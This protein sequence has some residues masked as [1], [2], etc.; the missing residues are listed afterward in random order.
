[1]EVLV[2]KRYSSHV[3]GKLSHTLMYAKGVS[4]SSDQGLNYFT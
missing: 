1:M 2:K 3:S 4:S